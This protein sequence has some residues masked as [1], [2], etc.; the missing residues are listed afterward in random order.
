MRR[1]VCFVLAAIMVLSL[2]ACGKDTQEPTKEN[3]EATEQTTQVT[4]ATQATE[5]VTEEPTSSK[6]TTGIH[7]I[8]SLDFINT[9]DRN[10][11][12]EEPQT[13][14]QKDGL[15]VTA[16]S[17]KYDTVYGPQI[18]LT[19]KNDGVQEILLQNAYTA[20]NGFMIKPEIDVKIPPRK[21]LDTQI[22]LPYMQLAMADIHSLK[23]VVISL[24]I[25]DSKT[26]AVLDTTEPLSL[27]LT[28]TGKEEQTADESGQLVYDDK[29][30][31]LILK[32][33]KHDT[34]FENESALLV[35]MVN[36]TDKTVSV[37]NNKL[38]VNGYDITTTMLTVLL[39]HTCAVDKIDLFDKELE[40]YGISSLDS[41]KV[42]FDINDDE[43]WKNIAQTDMIAVDTKTAEEESTAGEATTEAK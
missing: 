10:P 11:A 43:T 24:R 3:T 41:V 22:S 28:G 4:E 19:V 40:E 34:L 18:L 14:Y 25:L 32:G 29:G 30:V 36:D 6:E 26:F 1:G 38:T 17:L 35:Y 37:G 8:I 2:V 15:T 31:K 7:D 21:K 12:M 39:P 16:K 27:K 23:E 33:I 20:V 5:T 9:F 42:S 13:V